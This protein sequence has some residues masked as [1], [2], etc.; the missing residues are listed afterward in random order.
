MAPEVEEHAPPDQV[1]QISPVS[2]VDLRED[3][4]TQSS[5]PDKFDCKEMQQRRNS[6]ESPILINTTSS[7]GYSPS[8]PLSQGAS[9]RRSNEELSKQM[10]ILIAE[11][12]EKDRLISELQEKLN[13]KRATDF[14]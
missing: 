7:R 9:D 5:S 12:K 4:R 13:Q 14:K 10:E 1:D 2:P 8:P 3:M 11:C 6:R